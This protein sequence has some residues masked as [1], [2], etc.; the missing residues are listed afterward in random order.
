MRR[1][2]FVVTGIILVSQLSFSQD[3][4]SKLSKVG[5]DYAKAYLQPGVDAFGADL[6]SGM[7]NTAKVGGILPFGLNLYIGVKVPAAFVSGSNKT[8]DLSYSDTVH[9]SRTISSQTFNIS[10]PTTFT[11]T[12]APTIFGDKAAGVATGRAIKDTTIAGQPIHLDS[13][14]TMNTIGG[15]GNI[16]LAPIPIPQVGVGSLFGTDAFVRY[17]PKIKIGDYGSVDLLGFGVRHSISQYIPLIPIDISVQVGWQTFTIR[18]SS[19]SQVLKASTFA[20]NLEVSKKFAILTLYGGLQTE[21][22]NVDVSYNYIPQP[23]AFI[24]NPKPVNISFSSK[25]KNNFRAIV[26]FTLG[27]GPLELN[28]DYSMGQINVATAGIGVSI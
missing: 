16:S 15:L 18:D 2:L 7:F 27:L 17:L 3:L 22:S 24:P 9:F 13:T 23:T 12:G 10:V 25:G 20:A 4:G 28:A 1:L 8:F 5:S 14:I 6:N 19:D 21:N 26:G 11:V